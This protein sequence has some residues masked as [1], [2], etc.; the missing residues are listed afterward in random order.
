M[1]WGLEIIHICEYHGEITIMDLPPDNDIGEVC[2]YV[3]M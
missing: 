2:R 1:K 3:S